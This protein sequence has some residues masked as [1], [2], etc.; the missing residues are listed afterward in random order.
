[1]L[2]NFEFL[3]N[4]WGLLA[5]FGAT[6][7]TLIYDDLNTA[8]IKIRQ[9]GEYI[10]SYIINVE[11]LVEPASN[12]QFDRIKILK[13]EG[14]IDNDIEDIFHIIRK[15]GNKAAHPTY[16]GVQSDI[17]KGTRKDANKMLALALK[18]SAWFKEIYGSDITFM[19]DKVEFHE[20][21]KEDYKEKYKALKEAF[22]KQKIDFENKASRLATED[23]KA[24]KT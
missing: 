20:P 24:V 6:A 12:S 9:L 18:L 23:E 21:V 17:F 11:G 10:A 2:S 13:R 16:M 7:E 8:V 4:E 1:M 5:N 15:K 22:E 19:A 14:L 3:K